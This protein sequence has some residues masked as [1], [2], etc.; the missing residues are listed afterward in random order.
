MREESDRRKRNIM[1]FSVNTTKS[2]E[3]SLGP[4]GIGSGVIVNLYRRKDCHE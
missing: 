4:N 3:A 1:L 2:T